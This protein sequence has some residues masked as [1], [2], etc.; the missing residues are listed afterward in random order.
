MRQNRSNGNQ[1]IFF[2]APPPLTMTSSISRENLEFSGINNASFPAFNR[3][4]AGTIDSFAQR[5]GFQEISP[6]IDT[7]PFFIESNLTHQGMLLIRNQ[8]YSDKLIYVLDD[9][10][11]L[12]VVLAI[13]PSDLIY[14]IITTDK[15]N[16]HKTPIIVNGNSI[17]ILDSLGTS[18]VAFE[19]RSKILAAKPSAQVTCVSQLRQTAISG[20]GSEAFLVVAEALRLDKNLFSFYSNFEENYLPPTF[21]SYIQ[22]TDEAIKCLEKLKE[23]ENFTSATKNPEIFNT[24][25]NIRDRLNRGN[26]PTKSGKKNW[27]PTIELAI[28]EQKQII[29]QCLRNNVQDKELFQIL[30]DASPIPALRSNASKLS[31]LCSTHEMKDAMKLA[32]DVRKTNNSISFFSYSKLGRPSYL[33]EKLNETQEKLQAAIEQYLS[34]SGS[35]TPVSLNQIAA[36]IYVEYKLTQRIEG[37]QAPAELTAKPR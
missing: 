4:N 21:A 2:S 25:E 6:T 37:I 9:H 32:F 10:D 5:T 27:N 7:S 35:K 30:Y 23:L 34:T 13:A 31:S 15:R 1:P 29:K 33:A 17:I 18:G 28:D 8:E 12:K 24:I 19:L 14:G 22:K 36:L 26:S 3:S 16:Y 20:C 11:A